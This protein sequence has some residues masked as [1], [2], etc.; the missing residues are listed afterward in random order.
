[1]AA[2]SWPSIDVTFQPQ[3]AKRA[4]WSVESESFSGPSMVT[5]LSSNSTV[6]RLRRR[7]PA[8]VIASCEIPSI[9]Q[10]S[11]TTA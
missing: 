5:E 1:M 10:P 6:S 8:R 11:P 3:A 7:C 2:G 4:S 9:R